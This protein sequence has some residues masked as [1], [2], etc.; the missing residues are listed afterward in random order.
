MTEDADW[1]PLM[2]EVHRLIEE[3]GMECPE[4]D[5][6]PLC[7]S[8]AVGLWLEG[9]K[10]AQPP[11]PD[12]ASVLAGLVKYWRFSLDRDYVR[13][14]DADLAELLDDLV[15]VAQRQAATGATAAGM[16]DTFPPRPW[17]V[18]DSCVLDANGVELFLVH[19]VERW[20]QDLTA[21][22]IVHVVNA[23]PS[24]LVA[25]GV[26][27]LLAECARARNAYKGGPNYLEPVVLCREIVRLLAPEGGQE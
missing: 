12:A 15:E 6:D 25:P 18:R 8:I 23:S 13:S 4:H 1:P 3:T 2:D 17:Q 5:D 19:N 22:W 21:R 7:H 16:P 20:E 11:A 26:A 10:Q 24:T 14:A 27:A 9:W